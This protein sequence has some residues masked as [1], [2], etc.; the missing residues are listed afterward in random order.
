MF[1]KRPAVW[2]HVYLFIL[3]LLLIHILSYIIQKIK[4]KD[5]PV[6]R[7]RICVF[8]FWSFPWLNP[9]KLS[10]IQILHSPLGHSA[11]FTSET[12]DKFRL[13]MV[14]KDFHWKLTANSFFIYIGLICWSEETVT[15][16]FADVDHIAETQNFPSRSTGKY[17]PVC[18]IVEFVTAA[19]TARLERA[20]FFGH[21][22]LHRDLWSSHSACEIKY[23]EQ[24]VFIRNAL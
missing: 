22:V 18:H 17:E 1:K 21:G 4:N 3:Q 20:L 9:K 5:L 19:K 8:V 11:C 13:N 6:Q 7:P 14:F 23:V 2:R 24:K 16:F 10:I 12:I 15:F